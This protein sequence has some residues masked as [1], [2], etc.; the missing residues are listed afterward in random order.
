M[1]FLI[2]ELANSSL[3]I[4]RGTVMVE[5]PLARSDFWSF[6]QTESRN[7]IRMNNAIS[8]DLCLSRLG[9][10]GRH[11]TLKIAAPTKQDSPQH[12]KFCKVNTGE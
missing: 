9:I 11:L 12:W 10:S 8:N 4:L 3:I 7:L 2:Q 6:I 5:N 1:D